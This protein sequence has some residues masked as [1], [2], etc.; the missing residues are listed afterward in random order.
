ML[1]GFQKAS[2]VGTSENV[3]CSE[4]I[5]GWSLHLVLIRVNLERKVMY[6]CQQGWDQFS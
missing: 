5:P 2:E 4:L 6:I 3:Q 1:V